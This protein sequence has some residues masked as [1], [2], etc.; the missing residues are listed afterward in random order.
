VDKHVSRPSLCGYQLAIGYFWVVKCGGEIYPR[1]PYV[2]LFWISLREV[3][4]IPPGATQT[5]VCKKLKLVWFGD[6]KII[7]WNL[8]SGI[9]GAC[10]ASVFSD[11]SMIRCGDRRTGRVCLLPVF[12]FVLFVNLC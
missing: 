6:F 4:S 3:V 8:Y 5:A 11:I 9:P 1:F 10:L 12:W 7:C 2:D